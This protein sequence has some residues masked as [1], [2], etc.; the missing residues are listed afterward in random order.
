MNL[1][2]NA[3]TLARWLFIRL[4]LAFS[5]PFSLLTAWWILQGFRLVN[6]AVAERVYSILVSSLTRDLPTPS[7]SV[8]A[9]NLGAC[10]YGAI[11][12]ILFTIG[13]FLA[14]N[15]GV[16]SNHIWLRVSRRFSRCDAVAPSDLGPVEVTNNPYLRFERIGIVLS[17]GGAKGAFQA[18]ALQAIY[19]HLAKH[20]ALTKVRSISGTSI[21]S[22]NGVFWLA[23][24]IH[25]PG[26]DGQSPTLKN[27]WE[28]LS[29]KKFTAPSWYVPGLKN[30]FLS[31]MPWQT[32]FDDIF[33]QDVA[34]R[35]ISES[36]IHFYF[37]RSNVGSGR[38]ECVTNNPSPPKLHHVTYEILKPDQPNA[39]ALQCLKM[40]V[41]AS[42]DLPPLFPYVKIGDNYFEDGG[43]IDNLPISFAALEDCDL[44]F[45]LPLNADFDAVPNRTSLL[46]RLYRVMDARQGAL[47]RS[48]M[49]LLYLYNELAE[50][51]AVAAK[52]A[53]APQVKDNPGH[54]NLDRALD[55]SNQPISVFSVC[56]QRSFVESTI[57]TQEFWKTKEAGVAFRIMSEATARLLEEFDFEAA[58]NRVRTALVGRTGQVVW[59]ENF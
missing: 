37:T 38:L 23:N 8:L 48:S 1:L 26:F 58:R 9:T 45:V 19:S 31:T 49:K 47:E 16:L 32:C 27:W 15:V 53:V 35:T 4:P 12:V 24:L 56:P 18:G 6:N 54:A 5:L 25:S 29:A 43:V 10:L 59:D 7:A 50:L 41:F 2:R 22:W 55:R 13:L 34:A 36:P 42:M 11:V 44:I 51:R 52:A 28:Q 39:A 21:G 3:F 57:N 33:R 20:D 30:S 17:G 46:A 40:G 14:Y